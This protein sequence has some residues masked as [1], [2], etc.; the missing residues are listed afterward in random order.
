MI[1]FRVFNDAK[2]S[3]NHDFYKLLHPSTA[4]DLLSHEAN[5]PLLY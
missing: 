3:L 2:E 4:Q 5:Q 1:F